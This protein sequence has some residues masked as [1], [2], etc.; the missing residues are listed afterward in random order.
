MDLPRPKGWSGSI[1]AAFVAQGRRHLDHPAADPHLGST[2]RKRR[3]DGRQM[4]NPCSGAILLIHGN[5]L[6][7][8]LETIDPVDRDRPLAKAARGPQ[9]NPLLYS[10][11]AL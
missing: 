7:Y 10:T 6:D 9:L 5:S 8:T 3:A 4:A 2:G 11:M 1:D